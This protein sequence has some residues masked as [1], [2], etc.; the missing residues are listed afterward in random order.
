[1]RN[2][3]TVHQR[4]CQ[5]CSS[6]RMHQITFYKT[7]TL[8]SNRICIKIIFFLLDVARR[9]IAL[10]RYMYLPVSLNRHKISKPLCY[11]PDLVLLMQHKVSCIHAPTKT[12][13]CHH[14]QNRS[15]E[16]TMMSDHHDLS[17]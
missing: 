14:H 15:A 5:E 3:V 9:V 12:L 16:G 10:V 13:G 7:L 2:Q 4:R 8:N 17:S 1:M 6:F 11:C